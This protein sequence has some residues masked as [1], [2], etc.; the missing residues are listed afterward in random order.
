[1]GRRQW[2]E[3]RTGKSPLVCMLDDRSPQPDQGPGRGRTKTAG[4]TIKSRWEI[5]NLCQ[6]H[7]YMVCNATLLD[8]K[9]QR[10]TF[11]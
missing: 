11:T 3:V 2:S 10:G 5:R 7:D 6:R 8:C 4:C 9:R 1:M